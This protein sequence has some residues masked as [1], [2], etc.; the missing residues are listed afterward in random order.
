[1]R[2]K[3]FSVWRYMT[4]PKFKKEGKNVYIASRKS[5]VCPECIEI[6]DNVV[7]GAHSSI[8]AAVNTHRRDVPSI[9]IGSNVHIG[10]NALI[11]VV[12]NTVKSDVP[13]IIIG[14][15]VV[16]TGMLQIH[17]LDAVTIEDNVMLAMNVFIVDTSHGFAN[18]EIPYK[19]QGF[20][21][22]GKVIIGNGSWIG[23]NVVV[24]SNVKIGRQCI[25]GANSVVT[26][27]IPD[28]SIAAGSPAVVKKYWDRTL[29]EWIPKSASL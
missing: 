8:R 20:F 11:N 9:C 26:A 6:G 12:K 13:N 25:I 28:F 22:T 18:G 5:I 19:D 2:A 10:A 23:Q 27:D 17:A 14:D 16:S 1:M 3:F 21:R 24:L 4:L 7:I 29:K 15:N